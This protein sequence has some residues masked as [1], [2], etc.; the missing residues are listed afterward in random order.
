MDGPELVHVVALVRSAAGVHE[1][2]HARDQQGGLVMRHGE[3]PGE[4]GAGLS[5][6]SLTVAEEE[7]VGGG[8]PVPELACLAHEAAGQKG[9]ALDLAAGAEDEVL[10]TH[11]AAHYHWCELIG[12][13]AAVV[14]AH[15][16]VDICAVPHRHI[17]DDSAVA[18]A[19]VLT[20]LADGGASA[21]GICP[22]EGG[23]LAVQAAAM[24]VHCHDVC[25]VRAQIVGHHNLAAAGLVEH[26]HFHSVSEGGFSLNGQHVHVVHKGIVP[27]LIVGDIFPGLADKHTVPQR[28]VM[29]EC[30][31]DAVA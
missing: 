6:L 19:H 22:G 13:D 1:R 31:A 16:A 3:G 15:G 24:A 9:I 12:V 4:D 10:G 26:R 28:H 27:N 20:D 7:R 30:I 17:G 8:I 23:D 18:D 21:V 14:Q 29:Q 25:G 5:V 2:E 11:S